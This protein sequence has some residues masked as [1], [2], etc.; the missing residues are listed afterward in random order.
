M[1]FGGS[2]KQMK[3]L[4]ALG[5]VL[6]VVLYLNYSGGS[7]TPAPPRRTTTAIPTPVA[8]N[9]AR[10]T[11]EKK[12]AQADRRAQEFRPRVGP[13]RP[14][15]RP[16]PMTVD[17]TLRL[18]Q[19][20]RLERVQI[21]GGT[22]S[23]FDFSNIPST[24]APVAK[25]IPAVKPIKPKVF[26]GPMEKPPDPPK[27]VVQ[28]PQ[29]PPIPL[30]FYGFTT[31]PRGTTA[32]RGFFLDGE[33]IIVASEGELIKTRY[34]VIRIGLANVTMEDTQFQQQQTLPIVPDPSGG[35]F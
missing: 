34:K 4:G 5:V 16:D 11:Q 8:P 1:K 26:Y 13:A 21:S 2:S 9:I 17:P 22:R 19:L 15:D 3:F 7:D 32:K 6:A 30:K 18:D 27:V 29:A 31:S 28:K 12:R 33:A 23:L 20:T 24:G 10:S 35:G 25:I 14:E